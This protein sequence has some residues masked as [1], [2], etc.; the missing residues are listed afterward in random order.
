MLF[1]GG[2]LDLINKETGKQHEY[3]KTAKKILKYSKKIKD[4]KNTPTKSYSKT[5]KMVFHRH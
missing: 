4:E 2:G 3:Y 1:T 5:N